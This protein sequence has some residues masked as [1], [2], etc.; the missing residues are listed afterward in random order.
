MGAAIWRLALV[1]ALLAA[2]GGNEG[3][4][5]SVLVLG[6]YPQ[7]NDGTLSA[8]ASLGGT[9]SK[10]VGFT[11]LG[12]SLAL[13]AVTL[14]LKEQ[15]GSL[16]T[17]T[18]ALYGGG[19][20]PSG[21]ALVGFNI[22][23]IPTVAGDVTFAPK[24]GFLLRANTTYW[25]DV[26]GTSDTL[27][28]IVWYASTGGVAPTGFATVAGARF[29]SKSVAPTAMATSSIVNTF[30]VTANLAP[31]LVPEPPGLI[32]AAVSVAVGLAYA[33]WRDRRSPAA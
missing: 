9:Y 30:R 1:G 10:A 7:V 21:P 27:N 3:R 12:E 25:I 33:G 31:G 26:T 18:V 16:S 28:G 17:L 19:N 24:N 6:N 15:A 11:M 4:G 29:S 13:D 22:P 32:Q 23:T 5:E 2:L 8:V 14:R 20:G